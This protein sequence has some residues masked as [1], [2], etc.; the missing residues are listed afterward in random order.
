LN[1]IIPLPWQRLD[2]E[3]CDCN[4]QNAWTVKEYCSLFIGTGHSLWG[5][6]IIPLIKVYNIDLDLY[7]LKD[8]SIFKS[9]CDAE[10]SWRGTFGHLIQTA[11]AES[12]FFLEDLRRRSIFPTVVNWEYTSLLL[13]LNF[14]LQVFGQFSLSKHFLFLFSIVT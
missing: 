9:V 8:H 2:S 3:K 7:G 13:L 5:I 14:Y 1:T 11:S 10:A 12:H 4:Y 6:T